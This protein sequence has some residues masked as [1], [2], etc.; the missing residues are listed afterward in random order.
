MFRKLNVPLLG[1]VENMSYFVCP[2]C[3][4]KSHIFGAQGGAKVAQEYGVPLLAQI[5]L[6]PETRVGGDEGMP[7]TIRHPQ[8]PQAAAFRG[9]AQAVIARLDEGGTFKLPSIS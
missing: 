2:H 6:D 8:S 3:H 4:E 1:I 9:L 7:I 5:P